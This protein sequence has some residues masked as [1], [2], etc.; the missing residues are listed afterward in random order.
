MNRPQSKAARRAARTALFTAAA[1]AGGY[2]LTA[3]PNVEIVSLTVA[4]AGWLLGPWSGVLVGVFSE[5]IYGALNVWGLPFPPVWITQMGSMAFT[6]FV[7]GHLAPLLDSAPPKRR[8]T[9]ALAGGVGVTVV[10]D[11]LTNLAFPLSTAVP[12]RAWWPYLIAGIPFAV[13]HITSNAAIFA[14]I[15]PV[16]HDRLKPRLSPNP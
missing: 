5:A 14:L 2:L 11:L 7:F 13:V 4:L 1:V 12:L 15:L 10:F 6:G 16:A 3:V 8:V 9:L